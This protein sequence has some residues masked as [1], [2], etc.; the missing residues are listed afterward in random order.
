MHHKRNAKTGSEGDGKDLP[1]KLSPDEAIR[2]IRL[3]LRDGD[4]IFS[5]HLLDDIRTG[6]HG[7][8]HQDVLHVLRVG[9][10][11]SPPVWDEDHRNWKYQVEGTDL[12]DEEELRAI[13]V[14]IEERFTI[15][16]V[17]AY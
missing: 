9:E 15:F 8:S 13:T 2:K 1:T 3:T 5:R 4:T 6:R 10:I 7:V 12:E 11:I 14:V 17:T 16:V